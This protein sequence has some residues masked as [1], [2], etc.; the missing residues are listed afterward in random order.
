MAQDGQNRTGIASCGSPLQW[1]GRC[2]LWTVPVVAGHTTHWHAC[3]FCGWPTEYEKQDR[4]EDG[5]A[6]DTGA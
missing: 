4:E 1:C 2:R 6:P 5:L 3:P